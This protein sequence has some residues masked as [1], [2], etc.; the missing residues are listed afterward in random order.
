MSQLPGLLENCNVC[1]LY[2]T[3]GW[4]NVQVS[5]AAGKTGCTRGWLAGR[6]AAHEDSLL[7]GLLKAV[8]KVDSLL[9][10]TFPVSASRLTPCQ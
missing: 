2:Y 4:Q 7:S 5:R 10:L 1:N 6:W 3:Q 9:F 8:H